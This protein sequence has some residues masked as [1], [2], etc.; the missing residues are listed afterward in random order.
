VPPNRRVSTNSKNRCATAL[1][2]TA[3]LG[4]FDDVVMEYDPD[5]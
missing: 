1:Q 4:Y 5:L 3:F 2:P